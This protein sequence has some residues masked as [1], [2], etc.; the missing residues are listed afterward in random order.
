MDGITM[1]KKM[2][3]LSCIFMCC[4]SW[5]MPNRLDSATSLTCAMLIP[6]TDVTSDADVTPEAL[7]QMHAALL[8]RLET[9]FNTPSQH[10]ST[11]KNKIIDIINRQVT[12]DI[13][14]DAHED[15]VD[16]SIHD[17]LINELEILFNN[18]DDTDEQTSLLKNKIVEIINGDTRIAIEPDASAHHSIAQEKTA[19][20]SRGFRVNTAQTR[21]YSTYGWCTDT[22]RC[23]AAC[24]LLMGAVIT[25]A[26]LY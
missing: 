22:I 16:V 20:S 26:T 11:L 2:W 10:T 6:D 21:S 18:C 17:S 9:L 3:I 7:A 13:D 25:F 15:P 1:L 8:T 19:H 24:A 23:C 14:Q 4:S 5:A 12:I